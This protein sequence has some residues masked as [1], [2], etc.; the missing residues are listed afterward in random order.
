MMKKLISLGVLCTLIF[1]SCSQR[2]TIKDTKNTSE[3]VK[4]NFN[5]QTETFGD[6]KILRYQVPGFEKLSLK[7]QKLVY[8]LSEAGYAGRDIIWDQNYRHNL[9]IRRTLE[10]IINEWDGNRNTSSWENFMTYTKRVWFSNGIHH[11]YSMDK[12][13]PEFSTFA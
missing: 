10:K 5:F 8:Y 2:D 1:C 3:E 11:H 4:N 6:I 13:K 12:F 7:K 9:S